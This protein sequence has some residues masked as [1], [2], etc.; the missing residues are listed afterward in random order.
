M[1]ILADV[2]SLNRQAFNCSFFHRS[3]YGLFWSRVRSST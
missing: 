2:K 1:P 3:I